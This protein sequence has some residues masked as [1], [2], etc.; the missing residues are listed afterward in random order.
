M[1]NV[2]LVHRSSDS[3]TYVERMIANL[4]AEIGEQS[5]AY[6]I[7][8]AHLP[9]G[10]DLLAAMRRAVNQADVMLII[11]GPLWLHTYREDHTS[12]NDKRRIDETDDPVRGLIERGLM[13]NLS[14]I[15]V[16]VG[17]TTMPSSDDLPESIRALA[18]QPAL[19]IRDE[20]H[21]HEDMRALL[22]RIRQDSA[23]QSQYPS[24]LVTGCTLL[25]AIIFALFLVVIIAGGEAEQVKTATPRPQPRT[26]AAILLTQT[27]NPT[28][29]PAENQTI[30]AIMAEL[31]TQEA[32]TDIAPQTRPAHIIIADSSLYAQPITTASVIQPVTAGTLIQMLNANRAFAYVR[33]YDVQTHQYGVTG[34]LTTDVIAEQL[35]IATSRDTTNLFVTAASRTPITTLAAEQ[36]LYIIGRDDNQQRWHILHD[37]GRIGWVAMADVQLVET[38]AE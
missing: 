22:N 21:F 8:A 1:P 35:G 20:P 18:F 32:Q 6:N 36:T 17:G 14:V 23:S 33:V 37:D 12:S 25:L 5:L 29:A 7:D 10:A 26:Q 3:Q 28:Y 34:W 30:E 11:I 13:R 16:L 27:A 9:P 4:K 24:V 19:I 38:Q 31:L 2:L 15:P